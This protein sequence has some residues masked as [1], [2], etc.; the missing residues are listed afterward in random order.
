M[1]KIESQYKLRS[2]KYEFLKLIM[3]PTEIDIFMQEVAKI[4]KKRKTI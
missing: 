4:G 1:K 3:T 2:E